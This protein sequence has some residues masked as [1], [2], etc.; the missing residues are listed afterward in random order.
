[1][2]QGRV[3]VS[4]DDSFPAIPTLTRADASDAQEDGEIANARFMLRD[5][6]DVSF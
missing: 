1:M 5:Q 3:V 4:T 6:D 2:R